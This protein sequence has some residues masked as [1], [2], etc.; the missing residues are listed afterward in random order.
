MHLKVSMNITNKY[1]L[2][3]KWKVQHGIS[4]STMKLSKTY[5]VAVSYC[6]HGLE[7]LDVNV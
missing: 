6:R 3:Y 5:M 2:S 7:S 4:K 1:E